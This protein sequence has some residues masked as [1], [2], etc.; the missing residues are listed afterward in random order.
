MVHHE[1]KHNI[2]VHTETDHAS[3][4]KPDRSLCQNQTYKFLTKTLTHA[5]L[6]ATN[7]MAQATLRIPE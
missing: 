5:N 1:M 6:S 3:L 7:D 2:P 4:R